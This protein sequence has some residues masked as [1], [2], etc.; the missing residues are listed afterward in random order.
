M[1]V[2][3]WRY[4]SMAVRFR[5]YF[6]IAVLFR[7]FP[8]LRFLWYFFGSNAISR[9]FFRGSRYFISWWYRFWWFPVMPKYG[10][11]YASTGTAHH[12]GKITAGIFQRRSTLPFS[13]LVFDF[14]ALNDS[15]INA[16]VWGSCLINRMVSDRTVL[17]PT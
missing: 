13:V 4:S 5:Q 1:V 3:F 2:L 8:V 12:G 14:P 15:V 9:Y 16:S 17:L 6:N 10:G 11:N 7:R